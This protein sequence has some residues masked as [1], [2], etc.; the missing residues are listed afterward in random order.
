MNSKAGLCDEWFGLFLFSD[1]VFSCKP[2]WRSATTR[3]TG[4]FISI[5]GIGSWTRWLART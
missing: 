1:D 5:P 3:G 4:G 2:N